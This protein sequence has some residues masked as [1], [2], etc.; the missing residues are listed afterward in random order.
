M[1]SDLTKPYN[2]RDNPPDPASADVANVMAYLKSHGLPDPQV[3]V[4]EVGSPDGTRYTNIELVYT[5][6]HRPPLSLSLYL[7]MN[8]P[9]VAVVDYRLWRGEL[10]SNYPTEFTPPK[11]A[12]APQPP[13][14]KPTV[15]VGGLMAGSR[16]YPVAGDSSPDGTKYSDERGT[17]VKRMTRTPFGSSAYWEKI[18]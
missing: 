5:A 12:V 2:L 8:H 17:F 14:T 1:R 13:P 16:H 18:A 6:E 9:S 10:V 4:Q 11:P 15:L 7:V 3:I